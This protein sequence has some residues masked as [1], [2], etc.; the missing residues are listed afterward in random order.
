VGLDSSPV[1][2]VCPLGRRGLVDKDA[3][4]RLGERRATYHLPLSGSCL[5]YRFGNKP[6]HSATR[7]RNVGPLAELMIRILAGTK[8]VY[9]KER[10][11][12]KEP[13]LGNRAKGESRGA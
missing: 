3:T 1:A 8:L 7:I 10:E 9:T 11:P 5:V 4:D 2:I 6:D 13:V 12:Q